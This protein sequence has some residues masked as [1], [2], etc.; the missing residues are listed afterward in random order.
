MASST[1][2]P[3][4]SATSNPSIRLPSNPTPLSAPQEQQVR[5]LYYANVRSKCA[6]EIA[7]FAACATG[8]TIT[9]AW[10]CRAQKLT[11]NSCMLQYQGQDELDRARA[12][13]FQLAGERR[14]KREEHQRKLEEAR[15]KH[16]EWW[17]LDENG[18]LQGKK[19]EVL[20]S[21]G[22]R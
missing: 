15:R 2:S 14:E 10:A 1:S 17:G 6:D 13:W 22:K 3:T 20:A 19:A 16:K 12:Q 5:D 4:P 18:K 21:E 7:A 8:R 9:L 11:M